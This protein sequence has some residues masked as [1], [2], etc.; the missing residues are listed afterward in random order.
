[1]GS[2]RKLEILG[3]RQLLQLLLIIIVLIIKV[4]LA[5]YNKVIKVIQ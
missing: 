2:Y 1:M 3:D 5:I 4:T